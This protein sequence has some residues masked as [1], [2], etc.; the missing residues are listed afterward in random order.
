[1]V[2]QQKP[3]FGGEKRV[4]ALILIPEFPARPSYV[5]CLLLPPPSFPFKAATMA[6]PTP[7]KAGGVSA[8]ALLGSSGAGGDPPLILVP[9]SWWQRVPRAVCQQH[10]PGWQCRDMAMAPLARGWAVEAVALAMGSVDTRGSAHP[11]PR[12]PSSSSSPSSPKK[13]RMEMEPVLLPAE[14]L[15]L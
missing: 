3:I 4:K 9:W 1:M 5:H 10:E 15:V 12:S 13:L 2:V 6:L 11:L 8:P 14:K 7:P